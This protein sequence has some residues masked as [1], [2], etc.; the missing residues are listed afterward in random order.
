MC[1]WASWIPLALLFFTIF[2]SLYFVAKFCHKPLSTPVTT[3]ILT[4][5]SP[6]LIFEMESV[7]SSY[8]GGT[9]E[10]RLASS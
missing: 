8:K 1:W 2:K 3:P 6:F 7:F 5:S 9:H 10:E 4:L